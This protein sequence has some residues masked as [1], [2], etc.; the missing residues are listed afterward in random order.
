MDGIAKALVLA[1]RHIDQRS[2]L[3]T[4]DDDVNALE[5]IASALAVAVAST[6]EQDAFARMATSLGFPEL[7]EQLGLDSPR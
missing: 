4:E 6:T 5:E 1:V 3:H 2:N 7:V